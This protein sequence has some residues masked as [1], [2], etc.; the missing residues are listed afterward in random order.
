MTTIIPS[1]PLVDAF[2]RATIDP[3][4]FHHREHLYVAWCYL[5]AMPLEDALARY[6]RHLRQLTIAIG[7]PQKFHAT[8]TWAYVV[9]LHDAMQRSPG[10]TFD[11]LFADHRADAIHAHYERA[12]LDSDD[13][14]R[15]FVLPAR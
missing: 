1:D 6:V 12:Q 9:M 8:I 10:A 11:E 2:E 14:R 7:A 13:A 4:T 5:R 15:R 3:E